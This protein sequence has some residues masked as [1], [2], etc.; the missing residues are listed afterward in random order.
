MYINFKELY[1]R[2]FKR[3]GLLNTQTILV[4]KLTAILVFVACLQV[5]AK[6][7]GQTITLSLKDV[8]LEKVFKEIK[9]QA[10]YN[11]IY[12]K[13]QLENTKA[14]D[15]HVTNEKVE[16]VLALCFKDQPITYTIEDNYVVVKNRNVLT[17]REKDIYNPVKDIKGIV[18]DEG[19]N[20]LSS[21]TVIIKGSNIGTQTDAHGLYSIKN[22]DDNST[23]IFTYVGYEQKELRVHG[24]NNFSIQMRPLLN[25]LDQTIIKGYYNTTKRLNT[26]DVSKVTA[27]VIEKQPVLNAL[28]A[29]E[30]RVPGLLIS[31]LSGVPGGAYNVILRG[32]NSL[33]NGNEPYYVVD[34]V[35]YIS[36]LPTNLI[37]PSLHGG[38][39][40]NYIDPADIESIEVLKDADATSIY[41]SRA[42]NGAILITTK[43]GKAGR[44]NANFTFTTGLSTPSKDIKLLNTQQYLAARHEAFNNDGETPGPADHDINGDW[45]STRYT[46][47]SKK[48]MD[49]T[50]HFM[51]AQASVSGGNTNTQYLIGVGY[52]RNSTGFPTLIAGDGKNQLASAHFSITNFSNDR[53]FKMTLT[54]FYTY[55][56]NKVQSED[57]SQD[58]LIFAPDAPAVFN[59]DGS[60]NWAPLQAGQ[61]GTWTNPYSYL[62]NQY[63]A[64][65]NN[66]LSN[67]Q[68]S[69][70]ILRGLDIRA[71]IGY[72]TLT[73][74][75]VIISPTYFYDPAYMV[76]SGS[77]SFNSQKT[78]NW[79]AEPQL[80]YN[81]SHG[82]HTLSAL[83]GITFSQSDNSAQG[84]NAYGFASDGLLEDIQ[85]ASNVTSSGTYNAS[86]KYNA[87]FGRASYNY[88]EKYILNFTGRR[89]GSSKFGPGK[90]FGNFWS[91]AGAW[92]FS[93]EPI[94]NRKPSFFSF[95]KVRGSYGTT[96]SDKI[97]DYQYLQLFQPT[98]YSYQYLNG[99]YASSLF[100]PDLAWETDKKLEGGIELGFFNNRL[101]VE[102]SVYRN[103]SSN[104]LVNAPLSSVTGFGSLPAN[105]PATV[106]NS[107]K[108][109]Q[110]TSTNIKSKNFTWETTFNMSW[111]S[112]KL[113]SFPNL[114]NTAYATIYEVGKS[115]S[116]THLF[117]YGGINDT[118]GLYQF[119]DNKGTVTYFPNTDGNMDRTVT[120]D[121]APK[122]FGGMTNTIQYKGFML[123]FFFMFVKQISG[124]LFATYQAMPGALANIPAYNLDRWQK[125]G[126]KATYQ[127]F[128][129]DYGLLPYHTFTIAQGSDFAYGDASYI[130]LKNINISW[131]LPTEWKNRM[132][133]LTARFFI[134]AQN[135]ATITKYKGIDPETQGTTTPVPKTW[136]AGFN[137]SF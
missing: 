130:R 66:L 120:L 59:P 62:Y 36:E 16:D 118:T 74:S 109:L 3:S 9:K 73:N 83:A 19:G 4:M 106:Q 103:Q 47:W 28:E 119:I 30:G 81:F 57:F 113:V 55:N 51:N 60:L 14:I 78:T 135:L 92:I 97:G 40:L 71:S 93:K 122:F 115:T 20:P 33:A 129:Q 48:L 79:I 114:A 137:L 82:K 112:N 72:N 70:R 89:D 45:D 31:Q 96:G 108:E 90:Q 65:S 64:A 35:P 56:Q 26:G 52:I 69:Y 121:L 68:L 5:S 11:F 13:Q 8:P 12:S 10:G 46:N 58:R 22:I 128:S 38:S 105:L 24:R 44:M 100:N 102:L 111:Q 133:L 49:N 132:H 85:A 18:T 61:A 101:S 27:D 110:V 67:L 50:A 104:Q 39:P 25:S 107:G 76:T 94:F 29:I 86:Y 7:F 98:Y 42:A 41:G 123:N 17:P 32:R 87:L 126:D 77:S 37:N 34:G 134:Q 1:K 116:L 53:R 80:D 75:E 125:P 43:K 91:L 99:L 54:G 6:G 63:R 124:T 84:F 131:E 2:C 23:L 21:V 15:I 127:K 136:A 117:K 95:G 88:D